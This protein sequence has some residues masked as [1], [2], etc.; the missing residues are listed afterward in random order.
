LAQAIS[1]RVI[2][3][4]L[5]PTMAS[6]LPFIVAVMSVSA[7]P[8]PL[9]GPFHLNVTD[10]DS[11]LGVYERKYRAYIPEQCK[12]GGCAL[13]LWFHG[14]CG[15]PWCTGCKWGSVGE[16]QSFVTVMPVGMADGPKGTCPGWNIGAVGRDDVC[17]RADT[18]QSGMNFTYDSCVT[19]NKVGPCNTYTCYDDVYFVQ[20]LVADVVKRWSVDLSR[21]YAG[22]GSNG[23]L[24]TNY[25]AGSL[26]ERSSSFQLKGIVAWYGGFPQGMIKVP[27]ALHGL[28]VAHF[29]GLA[30][31]TIP[32]RGG[33]D[34]EDGHLYE[35]LNRTLESYARV[36]DCHTNLPVSL[37]TPFDGL[38]KDFR[39]CWM[40][41]NCSGG[42]V[43]RCSF[44]AQHGFW[45][46]Y[47]AAITWWF[48]TG[49]TDVLSL[50]DEQL[51]I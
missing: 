14:W 43:G 17:V 42:M 29:H 27:P 48:L 30:D 3:Q 45:E 49:S 25:L 50:S 40:Y 8:L 44:Q 15:D 5:M 23:A 6:V 41:P 2:G 7:A 21:V 24:F 28:R 22:G 12:K 46:S 20:Q 51:L 39:G 16:A 18:L 19:V 34:P 47:A 38:S 36:N 33:E 9:K 37:I 11:R 26:A 10:S 35:P 31:T 32:V 1:I 4:A 13:M